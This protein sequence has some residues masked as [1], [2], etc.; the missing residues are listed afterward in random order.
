MLI[1][2]NYMLYPI[3][4]TLQISEWMEVAQWCPTLCNPMDYTVH[5]ILQITR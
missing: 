3:S 5:G 2:W 4:S 1:L